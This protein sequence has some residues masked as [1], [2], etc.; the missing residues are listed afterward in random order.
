MFE[1]NLK[2]H[3]ST[4]LL[5]FI[6][7]NLELRYGGNKVKLIYE[8]VNN[9]NNNVR[10]HEATIPK[11]LS[12][13]VGPLTNFNNDNKNANKYKNKHYSGNNFSFTI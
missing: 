11:I 12:K 13:G 10:C 1:N 7:N 8:F 5:I 6:E 3:A 4:R 9:K 2:N